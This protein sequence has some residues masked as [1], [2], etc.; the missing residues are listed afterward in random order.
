MKNKMI[1]IP[2]I[3]IVSIDGYIESY[4]YKTAEEHDFH[5]S[6]ILS[7][8][9]CRIYNEA[10]TLRFVMYKGSN[11]YTLEGSPVLDPLGKGYEQ[12]KLFIKHVL[13]EGAEP[14]TKIEVAKHHLNTEWDGKQLGTLK[15]WNQE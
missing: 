9:G 10:N 5:H 11:T 6:Y 15:D 4:D 3:G 14:L 12:I 2:F 1:D 7:E 13:K 8:K